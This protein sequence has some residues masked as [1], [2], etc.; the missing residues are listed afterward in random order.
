MFH[1]SI[2]YY[3]IE[4]ISKIFASFHNFSIAELHNM[5]CF[6]TVVYMVVIIFYDSGCQ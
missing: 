3:T 5:L 6:P 4:Y 1:K 2:F